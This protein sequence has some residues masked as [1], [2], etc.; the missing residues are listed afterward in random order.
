MFAISTAESRATVS[1]NL[2][3][4]RIL[5]KRQC[6]LGRA[7]KLKLVQTPPSPTITEPLDGELSQAPSFDTT[8]QN[9]Y[10]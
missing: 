3:V 5:S 10:R 4:S 6:E 9:E 2:F 7:Y 1:W 8:A